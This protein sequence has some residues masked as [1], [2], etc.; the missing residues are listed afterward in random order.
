MT[1]CHSLKHLRPCFLVYVI[2]LAE[3]NSFKKFF[4]FYLFLERGEG[5]EKERERY[6]NMQEKHWLVASHMSPTEDLAHNLGMY[7]DW[8]L[9]QWPLG[10]QASTQST[11]PHQP[12]LIITFSMFALLSLWI[13]LD[14]K[15][16]DDKKGVLLIWVDSWPDGKHSFHKCLL[17]FKFNEFKTVTATWQ[18]GGNWS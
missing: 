5:M 17:M 1:N 9:N 8:E 15:W 4:Y 10:S 14:Y 2:S 16:F 6:T 3:I 7:P 12:G 18:G 13:L 11:K